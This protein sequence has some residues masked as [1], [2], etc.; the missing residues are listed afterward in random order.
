MSGA[1]DDMSIDTFIPEAL[2][3]E[4]RDAFGD[5]DP[6]DV[7][8]RKLLTTLLEHFKKTQWVSEL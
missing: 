1:S 7:D 6:E 8:N 2:W 3:D 4:V 5:P